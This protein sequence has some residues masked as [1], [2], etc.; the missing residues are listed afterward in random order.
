MSF[1][2]STGDV[3]GQKVLQ[4]VRAT[5]S[6]SKILASANRKLIFVCGG[7]RGQRNLRSHFLDYLKVN[8]PDLRIILAE[9]AYLDIL[10]EGRSTF[11]NLA[12]F[13]NLLADLS[14]CII[15]FPESRGS[16]AELGFFVS[17]NEIAQK[18]LA[19]NP[20]QFQAEESFLN[21]GPIALVNERSDF[22]PTLQIVD[23]VPPD[24]TDVAKRL[25]RISGPRRRISFPYGSFNKY[26]SAE[27]LF[28]IFE[29]VRILR[30][31]HA[32]TLPYTIETI[33][34]DL[35]D[36]EEIK[37][38]LSVLVAAKYVNRV[39]EDE[40]YLTPSDAPSFLDIPDCNSLII[41]SNIYLLK[42]YISL[43]SLVFDT[44]EAGKC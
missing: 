19:V 3:E 12:V 4:L 41:S 14:D 21:L 42:N 17:K 1:P 10:S 20:L 27:K 15:I 13:E 31:I 16:V 5:F 39:G 33:F 38:L 24:F 2:Y 44:L 43:Y 26:S 29:L 7:E 34:G 35:P 30:L 18:L 40:R 25:G 6:S 23:Q 22:R 36:K 11:L 28:A 32:A 9:E 8:L 37:H